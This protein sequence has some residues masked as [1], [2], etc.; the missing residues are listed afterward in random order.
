MRFYFYFTFKTKTKTV[1]TTDKLYYGGFNCLI[2]V[3]AVKGDSIPTIFKELNKG[4][5]PI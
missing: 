5:F 3:K 4:Y 2:V 1:F